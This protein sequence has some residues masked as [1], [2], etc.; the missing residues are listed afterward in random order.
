MKIVDVEQ[1]T[2]EWHMARL[3]VPTASRFA[4]L[5]TPKTRK[6][7]AQADA[8]LAELLAEWLM[9]QPL[10]HETSEWAERGREL[11]DEA[12]RWYEMERNVTVCRVG[13]CLTDDGLVGCSPDGLVEPDGLLEIKC[14]SPQRH[15]LYL[16]GEEPTDYLPQV[17]GQL[18]VTG[19]QWC[20][21]L[22][23]HPELPP[24]VR[25]FHRDAEWLQAI[26]SALQEFVARLE[27]AKAEWAAHRIERP[28]TTP[29]TAGVTTP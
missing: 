18:Y 6:P 24:I 17:H 14:L 27:A 1:G 11:E 4:R 13:L 9:N 28:W 20:D 10:D 29:S 2:L 22:L 8:L 26:A 15:V 3:G 12:R 7:S 25:R 21:L 5:V 23:Y 19:R 16:L